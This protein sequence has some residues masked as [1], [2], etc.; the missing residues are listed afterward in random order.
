[1]LRN[2]GGLAFSQFLTVPVGDSPN[3][4]ITADFNVDGRADLV[5]SNADSGSVSVLFGL[6]TGFSGQSYPAGSMPTALLAEDMTNDGRPDIL[7]ASLA[8]GD[9]RVMVGDGK[10]GFPQLSSF[11]GT[12]GA[13]NAVLQ[14][15]DADGRR[16]LVISSLITHRVSLVRN[17]TD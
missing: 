8:G 7:V 2:D 3:Y 16:D 11:P 17:I 5:V 9:F 12:W 1:V 6:P 10:G 15:M 13:S 4:L 14:D